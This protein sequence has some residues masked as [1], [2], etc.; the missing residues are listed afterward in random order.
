MQ[1]N[2]YLIEVDNP[3]YGTRLLPNH[4][5]SFSETPTSIR[6]PPPGMGEHTAEVLK[7]RLGLDDEAIAELVVR[8]VIG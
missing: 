5:V 6:R 7:E 4:P 3:A 8:G 1:A 2:D